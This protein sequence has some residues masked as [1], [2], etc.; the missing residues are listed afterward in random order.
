MMTC[1]V[2]VPV[3]MVVNIE[4]SPVGSLPVTPVLVVVRVPPYESADAFR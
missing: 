3:P 4:L 2:G 1:V